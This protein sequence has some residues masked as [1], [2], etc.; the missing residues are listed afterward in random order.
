M[1]CHNAIHER[2]WSVSISSLHEDQVQALADIWSSS[3]IF[4][5]YE[6]EEIL[7]KIEY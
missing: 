7:G 2:Y 5:I 1:S 4:V 6:W 3:V